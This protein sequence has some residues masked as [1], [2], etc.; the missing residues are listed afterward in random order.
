MHQE[1][2]DGFEAAK[3][4]SYT[5]TLDARVYAHATA[6]G[7]YAPSSRRSRGTYTIMRSR[8]PCMI[9]LRPTTEPG[10]WGSWVGTH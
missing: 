5:A 8:M 9:T 7:K 1:L 10:L 4:E 3:P 6:T 2:F